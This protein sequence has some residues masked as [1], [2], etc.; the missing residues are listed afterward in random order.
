[1]NVEESHSRL[2]HMHDH[3][4]LYLVLVA[5]LNLPSAAFK[6]IRQVYFNSSCMRIPAFN[7]TAWGFCSARCTYRAVA[8]QSISDCIN[9]ILSPMYACA[10]TL[11]KMKLCFWKPSLRSQR[12]QVSVL[13]GKLIFSI[14]FGN[15][16]C[17]FAVQSA[18]GTKTRGRALREGLPPVFDHDVY[19]AETVKEPAKIH[20]VRNFPF[21]ENIVTSQRTALHLGLFW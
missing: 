9:F 10:R 8:Q 18:T 1:M 11:N 20:N 3:D 2:A 16:D 4:C 13:P 5:V 12:G 21:L 14:R 6:Q 17:G 7:A 19:E 15:T